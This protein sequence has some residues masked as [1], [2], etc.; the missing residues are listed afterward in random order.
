M[1]NIVPS[2]ID[3]LRPFCTVE[4]VRNLTK[5]QQKLLELKQIAPNAAVLISTSLEND[6]TYNS[7]TDSADEENS[8]RTP[9]PFG[10]I[11]EPRTKTLIDRN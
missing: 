11:F 4:P 5:I 8:K 9:E 6:N 3:E 1:P 10:S 2:N 7:E